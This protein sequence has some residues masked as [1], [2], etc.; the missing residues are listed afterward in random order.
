MSQEFEVLSSRKDRLSIWGKQT[1]SNQITECTPQ[2][3]RLQIYGEKQ[4]TYFV[5]LIK[6]ETESSYKLFPRISSTL[7]RLRLSYLSFIWSY[8]LY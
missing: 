5:L 7:G 1:K 2:K 6:C 8:W 4:S 3:K